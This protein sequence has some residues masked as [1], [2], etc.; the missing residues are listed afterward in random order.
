[1]AL[2]LISFFFSKLLTPMRIRDI[3]MILG[4]SL[5]L[6][7]CLGQP[8]ATLVSEKTG[9]PPP[10]VLEQYPAVLT[11][12]HNWR[13]A[14]REQP[15]GFEESEKNLVSWCA[16][17]GIRAVGVGS[18]WDPANDAMFQRFE[19]PGRDL[20]YSGTFDQKSVMQTDHIRGVIAYLNGLAKGKTWFYLDNE[21]PK[22]QMGHVWWFNYDYDYPAWHDYSQD[23]PIRFYRNGP[24]GEINTLSG[25]PHVRRDLFEIMA[26]QH[27][28]GALGVFAHPT[29]WWI[30]D[31]KFVTNIAAL[32]GLFLLADGYLDGISVMSDRPFN[33]SAQKL[34]FSFLD[35]A[36]IVPGFAETDFFLNQASTRAK[37]ETFLNYMHLNGAPM[38]TEH[39]RDTAKAGDV[40]ASNGAFL[41][42]SV[43]G[44]PMGSVC[45]TAVGKR[46]RIRIEAY[47]PPGSHFSLI[48]LIGRHGAAL[49]AKRDFGGGVLEY[50]LAGTSDA[51]YV[52]ARAFGPGDDP[53]AAP[54][55]V[56][57]AAVTNPVY[58]HPPGFHI[59]RLITAC[60]LDVPA[61]SRWIGGTIEFQQMDG[62]PI[63]TRKVTPGTMHLTLP[64]NARILLK[65][66]GQQ[67][68]NF[69]IAMENDAVEK[70]LSY[71]T[72]GAFRKDYP[73][74][75]PGEVP[76]E[77][78]HL[79]ELSRALATFNYILD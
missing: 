3:A 79:P 19:G 49:A 63:E 77:A 14:D 10:G 8:I 31:G 36:A 75:L 30:S 34:W 11:H 1:L 26:T 65:K 41:T 69:S 71:L 51:G 22:T 16:R 61:A 50:E 27:R 5:F 43:D 42:I 7:G 12:T 24:S 67:D 55:R 58:L 60:T 70:L 76:P 39:I 64:A 15:P 20:Y 40:F 17:L 4:L 44:I 47:P 21:T 23:R 18:A 74:L 78:F 35:T 6:R 46:H 68:W 59:P 9:P 38:T 72:S 32:S 56:H 53:I 45:P 66:P 73:N 29:R 37:S 48:Q 57:E 13:F 33:T 54:D 2:V 62:A 52:L 28:A 25:Q